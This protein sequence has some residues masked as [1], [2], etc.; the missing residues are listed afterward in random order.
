[1]NDIEI[2]KYYYSYLYSASWSGVERIFH[3]VGFYYIVFSFLHNSM[4]KVLAYA[5]KITKFK[6]D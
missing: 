1:M 5:F 3:V 2:T 4:N 6:N